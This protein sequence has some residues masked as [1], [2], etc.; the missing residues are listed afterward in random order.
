MQ[1]SL[2]NLVKS[3]E[4]TETKAP[5][6]AGLPPVHLWNPPLS[7]V[8]DLQI[9]A[10][11]VW[12]HE[13]APIRRPAL[14]KLFA[15]ILKREGDCYYLVTP[16]EKWQVKVER[17]PL[18]Y[19]QL[20]VG[21]GPH[22]VEMT[23]SGPTG[24]EITVGKEHPFWVDPGPMPVVYAADGLSGVV[25]RNVYYELAELATE[26]DSGDVGFSSQDNWFSLQE[27]GSKPAS[28]V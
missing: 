6:A 22:G 13:G 12:L 23:L 21:S 7:G 25:A 4:Q 27:V 9:Q 11:G 10:N 3:L 20:S 5:K 26:N 1:D 15:S 17:Y 8:M 19:N 28:V 14:V 24:R 18:F 16:V 2:E